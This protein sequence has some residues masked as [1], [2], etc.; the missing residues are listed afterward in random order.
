[1]HI[2]SIIYSVILVSAV[3]MNAD[4]NDIQV[5]DT[6]QDMVIEQETIK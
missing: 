5:T 1:M 2:R 6:T 3:K 4:F